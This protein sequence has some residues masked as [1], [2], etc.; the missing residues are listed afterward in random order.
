MNMDP[1]NSQ[2]IGCSQHCPNIYEN[3]ATR[4]P[5]IIHKVA[6]Q[7]P[8]TYWNNRRKPTW[9]PHFPSVKA[10]ESRKCFLWIDSD[11]CYIS[12]SKVETKEQSQKNLQSSTL[13]HHCCSSCFLCRNVCLVKAVSFTSTSWLSYTYTKKLDLNAVVTWLCDHQ[14]PYRENPLVP[15]YPPTVWPLPL[16][17]LHSTLPSVHILSRLIRS[18]FIHKTSPSL[19]QYIPSPHFHPPTTFVSFSP[20]TFCLTYFRLTACLIF[21]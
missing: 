4:L 6:Q 11:D 10:S 16:I 13:T 5:Q 14:R 20:L 17:P 12:K 3:K 15:H 19:L 2:Y 7:N 18:S 8:G 21:I 1:H 9:F